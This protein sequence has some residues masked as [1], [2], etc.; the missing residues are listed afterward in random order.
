M[1]LEWRDKQS[2]NCD[3]SC[4]QI[5]QIDAFSKV[6]FGGNPAAVCLLPHPVPSQLMASIAEEMNLSETA[7]VFQSEKQG[8]NIRWF[9][10]TVEVDLCG[11]ATLASAHILFERHQIETGEN[12]T[13][14]SR[15]G[16]LTARKLEDS[17]IE[18]NFP[19]LPAWKIDAP[20][21]LLQS[22]GVSES[23]FIGCNKYDYLIEVDSEEQVRS[24]KPDFIKLRAVSSKGVIVTSKG[25]KNYDFVSRY[26]APS[27]GIDEDPV[28]GSAHCCLAVY[29]GNQLGK[30]TLKAF[31]ASKRGGE[32]YLELLDSRVKIIG[33]S[34]T[35]MQG[36]II[37]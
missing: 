1:T 10:P 17:S 33:H 27:E 20:I 15:S 5:F 16:I 24:L 30:H 31:Q 13:F 18:L 28:T 29:W 37:I 14:F 21:G 22:L 23:H 7:F 36:T 3:I 8:Y 35:V 26:F 25:D 6:P 2:I 32:I 12:V 11:H 4:L 9:T 34:V 19:K